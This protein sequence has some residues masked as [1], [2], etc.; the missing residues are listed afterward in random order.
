MRMTTQNAAMYAELE[1]AC[2]AARE[3]AADTLR[4]QIP[5]VGVFG[6]RDHLAKRYSDGAS[7][8]AGH[9]YL[10]AVQAGMV[11][12][13]VITDRDGFIAAQFLAEVR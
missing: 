7:R 11:R 1:Q 10:D 13:E 5:F 9:V 4:G 12:G 3:L 2:E 8:V 6:A